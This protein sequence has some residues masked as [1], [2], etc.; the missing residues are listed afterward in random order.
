MIKKGI[1][2]GVTGDRPYLP[3]KFTFGTKE[4]I[5]EL[6]KQKGPL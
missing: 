6:T 5:I 1:L 3:N 2:G 4:I